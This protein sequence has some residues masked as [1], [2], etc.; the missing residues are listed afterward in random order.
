MPKSLDENGIT[1]SI[2]DRLLDYEPGMSSEGP[3][4]RSKNLRALKD[5]V[6]R[7]LEWLL[8]TRQTPLGVEALK[9]TSRSVATYGLPDFTNLN[10]HKLDDQKEIRRQIEDVIELFEPRLE[11][12]VVVFQESY[13]SERL[14]HFRINAHLKID[15]EPE[16]ITFDTVVQVGSGN[17]VVREG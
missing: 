14:M 12:V 3:Q 4:S 9:E 6:R 17:Y 10:P 1:L 2:L 7:D 13:S 8:N 5:A 15:P 16:P 11:S